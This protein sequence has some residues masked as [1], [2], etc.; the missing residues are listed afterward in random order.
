MSSILGI[1]NNIPV[2]H[3]HGRSKDNILTK[4]VKAAFV[5]FTLLTAAKEAEALGVGTLS[6]LIC[7]GSS[8][9]TAGISATAC[10]IPC[11]IAMITAPV[12]GY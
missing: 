6:C 2:H 7:L 12:P 4:T 5:A 3:I 10:V 11:A 1:A 9:A 8:L